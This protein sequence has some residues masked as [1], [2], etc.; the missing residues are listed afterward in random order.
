MRRGEKEEDERREKEKRRRTS[1]PFP[2]RTILVEASSPFHPR[3]SEKERSL[4]LREKIDFAS[5]KLDNLLA[6]CVTG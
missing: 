2:C 4:I 1:L 5:F 6:S 3:E